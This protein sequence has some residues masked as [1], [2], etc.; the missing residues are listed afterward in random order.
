MARDF[1]SLMHRA[2]HS[3]LLR[4]KYVISVSRTLRCREDNVRKPPMIYGIMN[5]VRDLTACQ[6]WKNEELANSI[7]KMTAPAMDGS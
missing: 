5:Q 6:Q 2:L 7:T 3:L 1:R 4:L